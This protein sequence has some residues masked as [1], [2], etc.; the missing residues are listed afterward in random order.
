MNAVVCRMKE[1]DLCDNVVSSA[2]HSSKSHEADGIQA[3]IEDI[4][5][6][7]GAWVEIF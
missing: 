1:N 3:D 2:Y 6:Q 4:V 7:T 5:H